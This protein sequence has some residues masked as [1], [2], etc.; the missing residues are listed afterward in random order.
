[1]QHILN[2]HGEWTFIAVVIAQLP[3]IGL[4]V[5]S[6]LSERKGFGDEGGP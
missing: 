6:R 1:M 3:L 4:W 2:C 5:K